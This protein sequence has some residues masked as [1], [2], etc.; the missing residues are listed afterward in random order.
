[1]FSRK[2]PKSDASSRTA[3]RPCQSVHARLARAVLALTLAMV[4]CLYGGYHIVTSSWFL[5]PRVEDALSELTGADVLVTRARYLSDGL[6]HLQG[7]EVRIPGLEG[8]AGQLVQIPMADIRIEVASL[9]HLR[10]VVDSIV[11]RQPLVR[12]SEDSRDHTLNVG[13]L[14]RH[15]EPEVPSSDLKLP[16][17]LMLDGGIEVGT[18]DAQTKTFTTTGTLKLDGKLVPIRTNA[19]AGNGSRPGGFS[20]ESYQLILT[21]LP[22]ARSDEDDIGTVRPIEILGRLGIETG[23]LSLDISGINFDTDRSG[24]MPSRVQDWWRLVEPRGPIGSIRVIVDSDGNYGVRIDMSGIDWT[25]PIGLALNRPSAAD[26]SPAGDQAAIGPRLTDVQGSIYMHEKGIE[27]IGLS[28]ALEG[29][30][31]RLR[32][33]F[34]PLVP[35]TG[36]NRAISIPNFDL[37]FEVDEFDLQRDLTILAAVPSPQREWLE[38]QLRDAIS[39]QGMINADIH[40]YRNALGTDLQQ[41]GS[42]LAALWGR[43]EWLSSGRYQSLPAFEPP[44][45]MQQNTPLGFDGRIHVLTASGT[46]SAFPYPLSGIMGTIRFDAGG[47]EIVSLSASGPDKEAII[48]SGRIEHLGPAPKLDLDIVAANVPLEGQLSEAL[49]ERNRK[50]IQALMHEPSA[51]SMH[52]A[53]TFISPAEFDEVTNSLLRVMGQLEADDLTEEGR[54]E[55]LRQKIELQHTLNKPVFALGGR[56]NVTTHITREAGQHNPTIAESTIRMSRAGRSIGLMYKEFPYPAYLVDGEM[57]I[58]YDR[59]DITKDLV[60]IGPTGA[61]ALVTGYID[62][63]RVPERRIKA[64]LQLTVKDAPIDP[65]LLY[66]IPGAGSQDDEKHEESDQRSLSD[67][68]K[69][70][71]GLMID[72]TLTAD[73]PIVFNEEDKKTDFEMDLQL[74]SGKTMPPER[75]AEQLDGFRDLGW[76]WPDA[77]RMTDITGDAHLS[78]D[79]LT[80]HRLSGTHGNETLTSQATINWS[81]KDEP[82]LIDVKVNGTNIAFAR[83]LCDLLGSLAEPRHRETLDQFW[84]HYDPTGTFDLDLEYSA[85]GG[86]TSPRQRLVIMPES[87]AVLLDGV[88]VGMTNTTGSMTIA[89]G[90][91][92]FSDLA[93]GLQCNGTDIGLLVLRGNYGWSSGRPSSLEGTLS[94]G[95]LNEEFLSLAVGRFSDDA[96]GATL[97]DPSTRSGKRFVA[98]APSCSGDASFTLYFDESGRTDSYE[99][100]ATPTKARFDWGSDEYLL[101]SLH[102]QI[103]L[104]PGRIDL[105]HVSGSF[106]DGSFTLNGWMRF[107][108]NRLQ[109]AELTY[110]GVATH[111][112][113]RVRALIP[114]SPRRAVEAIQLRSDAPV[115]LEDA[116]LSYSRA[117][118][119]D[120][121]GGAP[122]FLPVP[123]AFDF[124][125]N[126]SV[127]A[128]SLDISVPVTELRAAVNVHASRAA[129]VT[130]DDPVDYVITIDAERMRVKDRVATNGQ[131]VL[132]SSPDGASLF[133]SRFTADC[134]GGHLTA[135][136]HIVLPNE[137]ATGSYVFD[138]QMDDVG[139]MPLINP[140]GSVLYEQRA[141]QAG[142]GDEPDESN[143]SGITRASLSIAGEFS[144]RETRRGRGMARVYRAR[145]Y[146]VPF[147]MAVLQLSSLSLPIA[148]AFDF[149]DLSFHLQAD[150]V[151]IENLSL[152]SSNVMLNGSGTVDISTGALDLWMYTTA[153]LRTPLLTDIW[154]SLRDSLLGIHVTGTL[155]EPVR[156]IVPFARNDQ[157]RKRAID[158]RDRAPVALPTDPGPAD[159][160]QHGG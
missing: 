58:G 145:L 94:Q 3:G 109:A 152:Q 114:D 106:Q 59:I 98:L 108:R 90:T 61:Q 148:S 29:V 13:A 123:A 7:V 80:I 20:E 104:V 55:L 133:L 122:A 1:M 49:G 27:L 101:T 54:A 116:T 73:G 15:M 151:E 78:R 138:L 113:S 46:V 134:Y 110:S 99:I 2:Q 131:A 12:I 11:L 18:H 62:R 129:P 132:K 22:G 88:R 53:G 141:R 32:G 144:R 17:I 47:V 150:A 26:E 91:I 37:W 140:P 5:T 67:G 33:Q 28:G 65:L 93:G 23:T 105:K 45:S 154:E 84:A 121:T 77:Y 127:D 83:H 52:D 97:Q 72:G 87:I 146:N 75:A 70:L 19:P 21:E 155:D 157:G 41:E 102:G 79:R 118:A 103:H 43:D 153:R 9:R 8:D 156:A 85:G 57:K 24:L 40:L 30:R 130:H 128:A 44:R 158:R 142:G 74:R 143:A 56:V 16:T 34:G 69:F 4:I 92:E 149:V 135:D 139:I 159:E 100:L 50:A 96:N 119:S 64:H 60:L 86:R 25:M 76:H 6:L 82:A 51:Q 71:A 14:E 89:G 81:V 68:A 117:V 124:R 125:S 160:S 147:I 95:N 39:L 42:Y 38:R 63:V 112:S 120:T 10:F 115:R 31:Y 48:M 107:L 35:G 111:F 66:A 126:M 36:D 137:T 136:G